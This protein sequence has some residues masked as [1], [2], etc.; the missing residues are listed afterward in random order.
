[1]LKPTPLVRTKRDEM[2]FG[3][4]PEYV[5]QDL[6]GNMKGD[7]RLY[8]SDEIYNLMMKMDEGFVGMRRS[9][10]DKTE[11]V[12]QL[13]LYALAT[14]LIGGVLHYAVYQRA[15]GAEAQLKDGFSIGFGGHVEKKDLCSHVSLDE[16]GNEVEVEEVP[17]SFYS[18]M[19]SGI[20][21]LQEEVLFYHPSDVER[22][23]T[24]EEILNHIGA[25]FGYRQF[26]LVEVEKLS[27]EQQVASKYNHAHFAVIDADIPGAGALVVEKDVFFAGDAFRELFQQEPIRRVQGAQLGSN[28]VPFAFISDRDVEGKPGFVG[29]TH[30]GLAA[31]LRVEG[32]IS[33]K[34]LEEK[35]TTIGWKTKEELLE[36][37]SR[38]EPWTQY[39]LEHIDAIELIA[40]NECFTQPP[41]MQAAPTV[42]ELAAKQAEIPAEEGLVGDE[43]VH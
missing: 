34:V 38:C 27:E 43:T 29:N 3:I 39:L 10:I 14:K 36:L 31:I 35:Y 20:R 13:I 9:V 15:A 41:Q 2:T 11:A 6:V 28:V 40:R 18:T 17:S 33:F 12:R 8:S 30:L 1:M 24:Q 21:E 25:G 22:P 42:E 4:L 32:D 7:A 26:A 16:H 5:P 37:R 23:F 19:R